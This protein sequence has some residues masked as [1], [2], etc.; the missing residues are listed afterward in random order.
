MQNS[1][2]AAVIR[3]LLIES[4]PA[5]ARQFEEW[6][7]SAK[8]PAFEV[9]RAPNFEQGLTAAHYADAVLLGMPMID[10]ENLP[11]VSRM[12]DA[13]PAAPL[14]VLLG[15]AKEV[16][17]LEALRLGAQDLLIKGE[18]DEKSLRRR[19]RFA[20]T[21]KH[22]ERLRQ[23]L[24][25]AGGELPEEALDVGDAI[26]SACLLLQGYAA[27][28][29]VRIRVDVP[30]GLPRLNSDRDRL[31]QILINLVSNAIQ[32]TPPAGNVI[33]SAAL[34]EEGE[35]ELCIADTGIG[36]SKSQLSLIGRGG[37]VAVLDI[38]EGGGRGL[39][40]TEYL[41]R[42]HGGRMKG[43]AAPDMGTK[44]TATFPAER[45]VQ[46]DDPV[47]ESAKRAG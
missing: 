23:M 4:N 13:A 10:V 28:Q 43:E 6:L 34:T 9:Q 35:M 26:G 1:I 31:R 25:E 20:I 47:V 32:F 41:V 36:M 15:H 46:G 19:I 38:R 29:R 8:S 44:I 12:R 30:A 24:G 40:L 27:T 7:C 37:N 39:P 3:I 11:R 33:V 2:D 16:A 18:L 42:Q 14:I 5:D 45:V 17:M 21:R 22:D